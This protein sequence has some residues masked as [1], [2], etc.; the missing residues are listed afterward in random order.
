MSADFGSQKGT[1]VAEA[2]EASVRSD[3]DALTL[4]RLAA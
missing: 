1:G 4:S 3:R 2:S